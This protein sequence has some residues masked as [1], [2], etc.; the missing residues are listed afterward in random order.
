MNYKE[1]CKRNVCVIHSFNECNSNPVEVDPVQG[2]LCVEY[3]SV[4]GTFYRH[5][6]DIS[7]LF[8]QR[9]LNKSEHAALASH[10]ATPSK[11]PYSEG[12]YTD[13]QL[14]SLI[15]PRH[16]QSLSELKAWSEYLN[17]KASELKS[18]YEDWLAEHSFS[19]ESK[20]ET[21]PSQSS[22]QQPAQSPS[23]G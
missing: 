17:D 8:Q 7:L 1:R 22:S 5:R 20:S 9:K 6:S 23:N 15:K 4:K 18:D 13:K 11:S 16:I 21:K 2:L 3:P 19:Q 14:M 12:N 10:F